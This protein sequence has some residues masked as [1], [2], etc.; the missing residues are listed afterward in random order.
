M[1][2]LPKSKFNS[3]FIQH[4]DFN[5]HGFKEWIFYPGMLY[6][7]IDAWWTDDSVR[8]NPHE[9]IDLC[10]Y[11]DNSGQVCRI[12]EGTKIPIMYDGEIVHIHDDFLGKSIYV[13]HSTIN[14]MGNILHTIYGHT[15]PLNRY[16]TNMT[17]REGD[18]IAEMAISPKNK[19]L[20][21]HIHITMAWL[22]ESI[23][24]KEINWET[25]GNPQLVTLCNPIEYLGIKYTVGRSI[26]AKE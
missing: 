1:H 4:N 10:F 14:D 19:K 11:K 20:H 15:I 22:P 26:D 18:I 13:K 12:G 2:K 8:P 25:I 7:D 24:Y 9:G 21:P 16:D 5:E 6:H 23:S 17:I 3:F